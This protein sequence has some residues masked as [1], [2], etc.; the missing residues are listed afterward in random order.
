MIPR[1]M[2]AAVFHGPGD[3][4][5]MRRQV[6]KPGPEEVLVAVR[7]AGICGT[8]LRILGGGHRKIPPGTARILGHEVVGEIVELGSEVQGYRTGEQVF[9]APNFGCGVCPQCISGRNNL[10]SNYSA[11]GLSNDGGF[12]EYMVVPAAAIRQGNLIGLDAEVDPAVGA[13]IEP[14]ACV[15]RG[16]EG[17]GPFLGNNVLIVG[18]G[19]IGIMHMKLAAL[20][21]A[22][23]II[24]SELIPERVT[25]AKE[26]GA[27]EVINAAKDSL[28]DAVMELTEGQGADVVIVAAPAPQAQEAALEV[29]SIGGRI[30]FFGGLPSDHPSI[31]INPNLVHYKELVVTGTTGC[32]T[33]D[34][35][36]AAQIVSSGRIDLALLITGK[37]ALDKAPEAFATAANRQALKVVVL[38]GG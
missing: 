20:R 36:R 8:D 5:L 21:G 27:D 22:R 11:I 34:C 3:L 28:L 17:V 7:A 30:N 19:P 24:I 23:K 35:R 25:Q 16:Q 4:R 1:E 26:L 32:S 29:A 33:G 15:L 10:C 14:L 6:P 12:A 2:L 31:S 38:P 13:L 9:V 37:F 18:A